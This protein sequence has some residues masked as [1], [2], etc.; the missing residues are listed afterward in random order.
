MPKLVG[1]AF[2][3]LLLIS[4]PAIHPE[5][6]PNRKDKESDDYQDDGD[7]EHPALYGGVG[8]ASLI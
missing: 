5:Q 2:N 7:G 3:F 8:R 6:K 4:L 1:E